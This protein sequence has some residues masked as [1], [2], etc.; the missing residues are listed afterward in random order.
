M[1]NK[2]L[3]KYRAFT[4][5]EILMVI[6]LTSFLFITM[7]GAYFRIKDLLYD[8]GLSAQKKN[9]AFS[10]LEMISRDLHNLYYEK[11]NPNSFFEGKK[12]NIGSNNKK[13]DSMNFTSST[14]YSNAST[15]QNRVFS[16]YYFGKPDKSDNIYLFRQESAFVDY[17]EKKM[18]NTHSYTKRCHTFQGALLKQWQHMGR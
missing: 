1:K 9:Q 14:L 16:I 6:A 15:M 3:K 18:G 13:I 17:K 2:V 10:I 7:F 5:I 12:D 11:W 8:Q 4:L